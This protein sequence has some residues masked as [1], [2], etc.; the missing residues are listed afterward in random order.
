MVWEDRRVVGVD[1]IA[2]KVKLKEG[3]KGKEREGGELEGKVRE[4]PEREEELV[5]RK[6]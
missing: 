1:R 6:G 4:R 5:E 2:R 3:R